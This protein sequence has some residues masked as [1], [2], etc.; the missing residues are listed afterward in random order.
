MRILERIADVVIAPFARAWRSAIR[1]E[2]DRAL[3]DAKQRLH[4]SSSHEYVPAA[5][6]QMVED[7]VRKAGV[8]AEPIDLQAKYAGYVEQYGKH[9][10]YGDPNIER[11]GVTSRAHT[12]AVGL[13]NLGKRS[14]Q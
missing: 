7:E 5:T 2:V 12:H 13:G 14:S 10:S 3:H 8:S 6:R 4:E 11:V 1:G 9:A